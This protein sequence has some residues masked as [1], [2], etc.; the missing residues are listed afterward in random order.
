MTTMVQDNQSPARA[1]A[2]SLKALHDRMGGQGREKDERF[3]AVLIEGVR[4]RQ[5]DVSGVKLEELAQLCFG[6]SWRQRLADRVALR[7]SVHEVTAMEAGQPVVTGLF[8]VATGQLIFSE[9]RRHYELEAFVFSRE[10]PVTPSGILGEEDVPEV[11]PMGDAG[12]EVLEGREYPSASL[13]SAKYTLPASA[14]KGMKIEVSEEALSFTGQLTMEIM[15]QAAAIGKFLGLRREISLIDVLIGYVNNY[16]R[17]G[18]STNTYLTSGAYVNNQT[19]VPLADYTDIES[20]DLLLQA[21]RDPD[22]SLPFMQGMRRHLVVMP[23]KKWTA[24]RILNATE[25]RTGDITTGS[26][27]QMITGNPLQ[28]EGELAILT[29]QLLYDRVLATVESEAAKAQAGWFYGSLEAFGWKE[30]WPLQVFQRRMES[31]A[32]FDRDVILAYK[33]RY[34]GVAYVREPRLITRNEDSAWA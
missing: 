1:T 13:S 4:D 3:A 18:T 5:I 20:A 21:M 29:S 27:L 9:I 7:E 30:L 10:I 34:H 17:N 11:V 24:K 22:N 19:G 14:K 26:G 16:K 32:A 31:D 15:R 2:R 25:V 28:G 12:E 8:Q 6:A 23:H 33:A